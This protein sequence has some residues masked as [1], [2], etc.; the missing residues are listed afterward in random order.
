MLPPPVGV[1][2]C[3]IAACV[4]VCVCTRVVVIESCF[5]FSFVHTRT[6]TIYREQEYT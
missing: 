3:Y 2:L 4:A 5:F 6:R 1:V